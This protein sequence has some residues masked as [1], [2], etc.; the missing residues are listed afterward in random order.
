MLFIEIFKSLY[1]VVFWDRRTI[2]VYQ[3][4]TIDR[5]SFKFLFR[6]HLY[7]LEYLS[8]GFFMRFLLTSLNLFFGNYFFFFCFKLNSST[9]KPGIIA[10]YCYTLPHIFANIIE[11]IK[12]SMICTIKYRIITEYT[13]FSSKLNQHHDYNYICSPLC[14]KLLWFE[15]VVVATAF[16]NVWQIYMYH[17]SYKGETNNSQLRTPAHVWS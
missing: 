2:T 4:T 6:R 8:T 12:Y 10:L 17:I 7:T 14:R 15:F 9:S 1:F 11:S 3:S 5:L 16:Y 13:T